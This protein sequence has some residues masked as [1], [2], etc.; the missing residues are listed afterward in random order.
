MSDASPRPDL[1]ALLA[2]VKAEPDDLTARLVLA[3]WLQEQPDPADVARGDWVRLLA[4]RDRVPEGYMRRT[5]LHLRARA[6]WKQHREAWAGPLLAAGFDL[7]ISWDEAFAGGLLNLA[8][9]GQQAVAK[10]A[11]SLAGSEA[12]AWVGGLRFHQLTGNQFRQ[13]LAG[14]LVG[15]HTRLHLHSVNVPAWGIE[16]LA[17][18]PAVAGLTALKLCWLAPGEEG[19]AALAGSARLRDPREAAAAFHLGR[20]RDL[21]LT[22]CDVGG[23]TGFRDLVSSTALSALRSLTLREVGLT[24]YAGYLF[25]EPGGLPALTALD[26]DGNPTI[27]PEALQILVGSGRAGRL[28]R[29]GLSAT[30]AG[31]RGAEAIAR[32]PHLDRL[33]ELDLSRNLLTDRGVV[34]LAG[35]P[36]LRSLERLVLHTNLEITDRGALALANSPHLSRLQRLNLHH[37]RVGDAAVDALR[38]RFGEGLALV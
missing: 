22:H 15:S 23:D 24:S 12:W 38:Q 26:L 33:V 10:K 34:A 11:A 6:L 21:T 29:L 7:P 20:L 17:A 4:E 30:G 13:F 36:H 5:D 19:T 28:T 35:S 8:V 14:P 18:S 16:E 2:A 25:A 3:D 32:Q 37:T 31:D 1:L 9:A 27:G